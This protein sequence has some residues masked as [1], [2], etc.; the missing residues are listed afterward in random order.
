M[1]LWITQDTSPVQYVVS[2]VIETIM[3]CLSYCIASKIDLSR[4]DNY[5]KSDDLQHTA[6]RFRDVLKLTTHDENILVFVFKNG[7]VVSWGIK[8]HAIHP[9]LETIKLFA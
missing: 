2:P 7:T 9:Y 1:I 8:R 6:I 3:E 4:L 5:Y